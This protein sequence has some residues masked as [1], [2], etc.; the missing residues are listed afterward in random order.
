MPSAG[1]PRNRLSG[2]WNALTVRSPAVWAEAA[3]WFIHWGLHRG[4]PSRAAGLGRAA[5]E[6]EPERR[7]QIA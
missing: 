3:V 5:E 6:I 4:P 2:L 7:P 1:P